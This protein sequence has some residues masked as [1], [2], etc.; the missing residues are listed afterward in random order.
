M[1]NYHA[2]TFYCNHAVNTADEMIAAA[3]KEGYR[4]FG[5]SEHIY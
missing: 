2:H 5:I 3:I 4:S 1:T